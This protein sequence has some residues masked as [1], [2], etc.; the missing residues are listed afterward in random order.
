[1]SLNDLN[2]YDYAG[3]YKIDTGRRHRRKTYFLG[4]EDGGGI[5]ISESE[6]NRVKDYNEY[7][8]ISNQGMV[9][10]NNNPLN[11][12]KRKKLFNEEETTMFGN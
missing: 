8:T 7:R 5:K 3:I 1:M 4:H 6:Y 9:P 12:K 10:Q 2:L 11:T